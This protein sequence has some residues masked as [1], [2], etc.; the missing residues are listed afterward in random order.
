MPPHA[1]GS[2]PIL[3]GQ[4]MPPVQMGLPPVGGVGMGAGGPG[5]MQVGG[6]GVSGVEWLFWGVR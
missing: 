3:V 2:P 6:V 5:D 1:G 4:S